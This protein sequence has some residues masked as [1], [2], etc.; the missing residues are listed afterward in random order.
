M[1]VGCGLPFSIVDSVFFQNFV[2]SLCEVYANKTPSRKVVSDRLLDL[3]YDEVHEATKKTISKDV[4]FLTDSWKNKSGKQ[5]NFALI[6]HNAG[7][8]AHFIDSYDMTKKSENAE[9]LA[10]CVS[11]TLSNNI[12]SF[13]C[14]F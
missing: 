12:N 3:L 4:C 14:F 5:Q 7:E 10:E 1:I 13:K 8:P 9:N 6:M 11:T 2:G